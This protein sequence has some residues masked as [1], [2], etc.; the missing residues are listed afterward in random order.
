MAKLTIKGD[1]ALSIKLESIIQNTDNLSKRAVYEGAKILADEAKA[2]LEGNLIGSE[3]STGDLVESFGITPIR[4][5][6]NG[7]IDAKVGF[8]GYDRKGVPNQLKARAMESGTSKQKA[9]PF[10]RPAV[11]KT[12]KRIKERMKNVIESGIEELAKE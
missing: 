11:N 7:N 10:M 8:D 3:Y 9:R 1:K 6:E 5:K 2:R 4:I 12:R